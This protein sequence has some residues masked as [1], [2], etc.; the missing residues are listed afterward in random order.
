MSGDTR[1]LRGSKPKQPLRKNDSARSDSSSGKNRDP[2]WWLVAIGRILYTDRELSVFLFVLL[3]PVIAWA[4]GVND[5]MY[6]ALYMGF[7]SVI[8]TLWLIAPRHH[9]RSTARR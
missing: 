5:P 2:Q 4:V 6:M 1:R 7:A 9:P 8:F 3:S